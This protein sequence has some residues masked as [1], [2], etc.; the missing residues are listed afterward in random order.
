MLSFSINQG[1]LDSPRPTEVRLALCEW[2][3]VEEDEIPAIFSVAWI[4]AKVYNCTSGA[5]QSADFGRVFLR[6]RK[7]I[8]FESIRRGFRRPE[9]NHESW[10][11]NHLD[12]IFSSPFGEYDI[13]KYISE[14]VGGSQYNR[15][16]LAATTH[17]WLAYHATHFNSQKSYLKTPL[18]CIE[19]DKHK[20]DDDSDVMRQ[21]RAAKPQTL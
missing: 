15:S 7:S 6:V 21:K 14:A 9:S 3:D 2:L 4:V 5:E 20:Y 13:G 12:W 1:D 17:T 19:T 18:F 8:A 10:F 16:I 11:S